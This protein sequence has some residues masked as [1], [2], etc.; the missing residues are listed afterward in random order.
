MSSISENDIFLEQTCSPEFS[1]LK[2]ELKNPEQRHISK[3]S[4]FIQNSF[5]FFSNR[6]EQRDKVFVELLKSYI[7]QLSEANDILKVYYSIFEEIY[8]NVDSKADWDKFDR[9]D[10]SEQIEFWSYRECI[11]AI[12][13][14]TAYLLSVKYKNIDIIDDRNRILYDEDCTISILGSNTLVS[15]V[16][17]TISAE[18][19]SAWI[20]LIEDLLV[21]LE[22][23]NH[24]KWKI[25]FYGDF[26]LVGE[27]YI[28]THHLNKNIKTE[29]LK[30]AT[31]SYF[32]HEHS[33]LFD[34]SVLKK[35][36]KWC[37]STKELNI[38]INIL[39]KYGK[40]KAHKINQNDRESYYKYLSEAEEL[41]EKTIGIIESSTCTNIAI[42]N[43]F[44]KVM[45]QLGK[46]NLYRTENYVLTSTTTHIV[47]IEQAKEIAVDHCNPLLTKVAKCSLSKF[48]YVLSAIE[49]LGYMQEQ[50]L[51]TEKSCTLSSNKYF[52]RFIRAIKEVPE[53]IKNIAVYNQCVKLNETLSLEKD[54]RAKKNDLNQECISKTNLYQLLDKLI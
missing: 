44:G 17:I 23:F 51:E 32:R 37:I 6:L 15:D 1:D 34:L 43:L 13:L 21:S 29:L 40:D 26:M 30:L 22:W 7:N 28:D 41:E 10:L 16:D 20:S 50:I 25:D 46:A 52:G 27:Y 31:L 12:T 42:S 14:Y 8:Y 54:K 35:L 33:D 38:D 9:T 39:L 45:V 18:H 5:N 19:G 2:I 4:F 48:A 36:L 49:Q 47:K 11:I 53:L 3:T 24:K